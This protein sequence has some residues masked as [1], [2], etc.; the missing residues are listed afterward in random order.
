MSTSI[1][2]GNLSFSFTDQELLEAFKTVGTV[3]RSRIVTDR[4]TG[5]SRGF[6]FVE[7]ASDTE[8]AEAIRRFDGQDLGGR[9][10]RVNEAETRRPPGGGGGPRPPR[11]NSAPPT[12]ADGGGGGG[13]DA[14]MDSGFGFGGRPFQNNKGSRRGLRGRKRSIR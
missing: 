6:A 4:E 13:F 12:F 5:R 11:F 1:F 10:V 7:F 3:V 8:A 2:V 14:P 9:T